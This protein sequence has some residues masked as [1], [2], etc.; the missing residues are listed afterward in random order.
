MSRL[1]AYAL[2]LGLLV[3][4]ASPLAMRADDWPQWL[5]PNREA[6]WNETGIVDGFSEGGPKI[7]WRVPVGYGYS[8]PA[9]ADG[10]VYVADF[11][12]ASGELTNNPGARDRLSG[13]ERLLC[14]D[15]ATGK[16]LWAFAEDRQYA[17]SYPGGPRC[18][19]T[20]DGDLVFFLGAEG[21]LVCLKTADG[22]VVWKKKLT[23]EYQTET[24]I[25]GF[26]AHPL[27]VGDLLYCVVGGQGTVAV[28][29]DKRTGKEVWRALSAPEP[30]Y[31]PPTQ[32]EQNGKPVLAV[33]H[34]EALNGLDLA[35]GAVLWS[36]PL[37]PSY[38][39]SIMA[40]RQEGDIL[41]AAGIGNVGAA[42]RLPKGEGEPDV[43][44]R[45]NVRTG[46]HPVNST[47]YVLDG[48]IYGN[49]GES[50]GI[51]AAK[52][53][54]GERLWQ[55]FEAT[56]TEGRPVRQATVFLVRNADRFFL[57]NDQGELIIAKLSPEGYEEIDRAKIVEPTQQVN[58]RTVVWSHPAFAERSCFARNDKEIVCVDLAK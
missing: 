3:S 28:A 1:T 6:T 48:V 45:S 52:L 42:V 17:L 27:V 23:Q 47:P 41:F 44:W 49:D 10:K 7:K 21:D 58:N 35:T 32:I 36:V 16:Q 39:M 9:V 33:W 31:S 19:P 15:A 55:S 8:G 38:G 18:T 54:D 4:A 20:V 2:S 57:F 13:Q 12:K 51:I 50:G 53:I 56:T 24:P 40:P 29:F 34:P 43:L 37:K 5:G 25:W 46:V 14:L 22:S 26:A 30:G 11:V